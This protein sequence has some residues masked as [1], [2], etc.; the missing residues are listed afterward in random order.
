VAIAANQRGL[1]TIVFRPPPGP[2]RL[3]KP[4][5]EGLLP[6]GVA[7]LRSLGIHLNS[8]IRRPIRW[9]PVFRRPNLPRVCNISGL[10]WI[11]IAG[12]VR[13]HQLLVDRAIQAG[14]IFPLGHAALQKIDTRHCDRGGTC[15][16]LYKWIVGADGQNSTVRKM[17]QAWSYEHEQQTVRLSPT[18]SGVRSWPNLVDLYWG[19]NIAKCWRPP[20]DAHEVLPGSAFPLPRWQ[21]SESVKPCRSSPPSLPKGFEARTPTTRELGKHDLAE[22]GSRS[23]PAG[24]VAL[25]GDAF[26]IGRRDHRPRAQ[27]RRFSKPTFLAEALERGDLA[28]YESCPPQDRIHAGP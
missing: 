21:A 23:L 24:R 27:P 19:R 16:F 3:T 4:C 8:D 6:Q 1:R 17:G 12:G 13:L 10:G 18:F 28:H 22:T 20:T 15:G 5:G 9:N 14:V 11:R 2:R 26:R 7:S 25:V